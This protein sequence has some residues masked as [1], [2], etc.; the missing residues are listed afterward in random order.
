M[1]IM[2]IIQLESEWASRPNKLYDINNLDVNHKW[3]KL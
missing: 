2:V 3:A 1:S